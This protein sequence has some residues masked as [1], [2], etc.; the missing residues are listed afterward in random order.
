MMGGTM[1]RAIVLSVVVFF[2]LGSLGYGQNQP[3]T[4]KGVYAP[5]SAMGAPSKSSSGLSAPI[6]APLGGGPRVTVP[7][8]PHRGQTLPDDV[9]P[10]PIPDRPG[11]GTVVVNGRRAI[12]DLATNRIFQFSN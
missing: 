6:N 4:L 11:Y 12:I 3:Q 7:G 9:S 2:S 5:P 10:T 8:D 1:M